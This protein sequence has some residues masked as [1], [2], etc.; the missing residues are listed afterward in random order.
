MELVKDKVFETE[1]VEPP[2]TLGLPRYYHSNRGN[3][4]P[5]HFSDPRK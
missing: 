2:K 4:G 1:T 3:L 5:R